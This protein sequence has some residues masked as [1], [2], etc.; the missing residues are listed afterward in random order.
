M[1]RDDRDEGKRDSKDKHNG[2]G[3]SRRQRNS[4]TMHA[5]QKD[6]TDTTQGAKL[7]G[8]ERDE[9]KYKL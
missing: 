3:Y 1:K 9:Q 8:N 6:D 2:H 4:P 7:A 5:K